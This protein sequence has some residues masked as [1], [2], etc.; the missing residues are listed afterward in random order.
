MLRRFGSVLLVFVFLIPHAGA[1]VLPAA[2]AQALARAQIPTEA[3]SIVVRQAG[4]AQTPRLSLH[5]DVPRNPASVMKLVT[6]QAALELLG[7]SWS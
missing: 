3:V 2:V 5:A 1:A 4:A 7:P 6:T